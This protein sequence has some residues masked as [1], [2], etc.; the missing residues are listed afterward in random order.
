M[1]SGTPSA[2]VRVPVGDLVFPPFM[3]TL[4]YLGEKLSGSV[5]G[6]QVAEKIFRRRKNYPVAQKLCGGETIIPGGRRWPKSSKKSPKIAAQC[7]K[8]LFHILIHCE[9]IPY[10]YTLP[11]T[12]SQYIAETTPYLYTLNRTLPYLNSLS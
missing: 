8:S 7:R 6:R 10:P 5:S 2:Q 4:H 11:K 9:T 1:A 12:L 3:L